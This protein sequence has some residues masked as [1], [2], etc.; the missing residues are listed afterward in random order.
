[1]HVLKFS[2][3]DQRYFFWLQDNFPGKP[4]SIILEYTNYSLIDSMIAFYQARTPAMRT[5]STV[6]SRIPISRSTMKQTRLGALRASLPRQPL[7]PVHP[8]ARVMQATVSADSPPP[9]NSRPSANS[10]PDSPQAE[11]ALAA[12]PQAR[13]TSH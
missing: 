13:P 12:S 8:A 10:S 9:N 5:T 2:S 11:L 3:S 1:M 4:I 7:P 6:S